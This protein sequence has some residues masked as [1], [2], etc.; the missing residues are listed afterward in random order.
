M[1][2][3]PF[4]AQNMSL[5]FPAERLLT[6][7]TVRVTD[8]P[9]PITVRMLTEHDGQLYLLDEDGQL[10]Q[11][12]FTRDGSY[13]VF[14]MQNGATLLYASGG[15]MGKLWGLI[16]MLVLLVLVWIAWVKRKPHNPKSIP[17]KTEQA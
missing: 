10:V 17:S 2:A 14:P 16:G 11:T 6:A 15:H 4:D 1:L 8:Y 3:L 12:D 13:I 7:Y 5:P 9:F